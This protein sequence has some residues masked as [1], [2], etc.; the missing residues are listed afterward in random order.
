MHT[1]YRVWNLSVSSASLTI[2]HHN[3]LMNSKRVEYEIDTHAATHT[4]R[5]Q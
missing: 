2:F 5:R 1:Y 4:I 3:I